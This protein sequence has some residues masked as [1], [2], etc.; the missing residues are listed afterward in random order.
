MNDK[1]TIRKESTANVQAF[2]ATGGTI[3]TLPTRKRKVRMVVRVKSKTVFKSKEPAVGPS[4]SW[5][6]LNGVI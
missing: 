1:I 6:L 3:V 4:M 5:G 2:L